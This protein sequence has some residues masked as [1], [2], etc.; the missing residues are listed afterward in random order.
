MEAE[1]LPLEDVLN[2]QGGVQG[3]R[4]GAGKRV[5]VQFLVGGASCFLK[6]SGQ[7]LMMLILTLAVI[8]SHNR[9][10][11]AK[12]KFSRLSAALLRPLCWF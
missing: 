10:L 1:R 7:E 8:H 2:L 3:E 9:P 11:A 5:L 12:L 4:G 6:W